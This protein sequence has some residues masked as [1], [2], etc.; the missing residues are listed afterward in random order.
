[1]ADLIPNH[2]HCSTCNKAIPYVDPKR[3]DTSD[4]TC[5]P[6]HKMDLDEL[7]KKRKRSMYT[8][9]ALMGLAVLVLILSSSGF[10]PR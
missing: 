9:Y 8:M 2:M 3:A 5:S 4:R 7:N 6:E 1:M 10:F